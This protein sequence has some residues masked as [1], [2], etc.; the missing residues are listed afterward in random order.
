MAS[1]EDFAAKITT[2]VDYLTESD[3]ENES[4][5]YKASLDFVLNNVKDKKLKLHVLVELLASPLTDVAVSKRSAGTCFLVDVLD[6]LSVNYLTDEE[7]SYFVAFFCDRLK[8]NVL[9]VPHAVRGLCVLSG[10]SRLPVGC[11]KQI[12][13]SLFKEVQTQA[14]SH[15]VRNHVYVIVTNL[16]QYRLGEVKEMEQEFVYGFI[17]AMDGEKDPRSLMIIFNM[18]PVII[19]KFSISVFVEEF[20]EVISCYFPIDFSPP[21]NAPHGVTQQTLISGLR[22]CLSATSLFAPLCVPLLLEKLDS[23]VEHAK[24]DAL[25]TLSACSKPYGADGL[26]SFFHALWTSIR[27]EMFLSCSEK[28]HDAA[29][30]AVMSVTK[31]LSSSVV[32]MDLNSHLND[33]LD[34]ILNDCK[35]FLS[36]PEL[37]LIQPSS[38]ILVAAASVSISVCYHVLNHVVP[39]LLDQFEHHLQTNRKVTVFEILLKFLDVYVQLSRTTSDI[40]EFNWSNFINLSLSQLQNDNEALCHSAMSGV[41][42]ILSIPKALSEAQCNNLQS[43]LIDIARKNTNFLQTKSIA[44][45]QKLSVVEPNVVINCTIP[46]L[47]GLITLGDVDTSNYECDM[48]SNTK[49]F[50]ALLILGKLCNL[51]VSA[52]LVSK[53]LLKHVDELRIS[54]DEFTVGKIKSCINCLRDIV[55]QFQTP[56]RDIEFLVQSIFLPLL[57]NLK[58]ASNENSRSVFNNNEVILAVCELFSVITMQLNDEQSRNVMEEMMKL[59]NFDLARSNNNGSCPLPKEIAVLKSVICYLSADSCIFVPEKFFSWIETI[60]YGNTDDKL[61]VEAAICILASL[62]NKLSSD[63]DLFRTILI[64]LKKATSERLQSDDVHEKQRGL[65]LWIWITKALVLRGHSEIDEF[66]AILIGCFKDVSIGKTA[67]DGFKIILD[68]YEFMS[69]HSRAEIRF[70]YRQRLFTISISSLIK[71]FNEVSDDA[72]QIC[73]LTAVNHLLHFLP[74]YV[75]MDAGHPLLPLLIQTLSL[76]NASLMLTALSTIN[77]LLLEAPES[78]SSYVTSLVPRLLKISVDAPTMKERIAALNCLNSLTKQPTSALLPVR[79]DVVSALAACVDDRKR[80]V[81]QEAVSTRCNWYLVG[82]P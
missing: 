71:G 80:L 64:H 77:S 62:V 43:L 10:S 68:E 15:Q 48:D 75:I 42:S 63:S 47:I 38:K 7:L 39:M 65:W 22:K 78:M 59:L 51:E 25:D 21:P 24:I 29:L 6:S 44:V 31:A 9:V 33:F 73:Y 40:V 52:T 32:E 49:Y 13:A 37:K 16:L 82:A 69:A 81:R 23:D 57:N 50:S 55:L 3:C 2:C 11:A 20:F 30:G 27:R 70:L 60:V 35:K 26:S 12:L 46:A 1:Q 79:S 36:E 34:E 5:D 41:E 19:Q 17:Q 74:H 56:P 53:T 14:H 54:D 4:S 58:E 28:V 8:D 66:V 76:S 18:V 45:L 67:A 72:E 61:L